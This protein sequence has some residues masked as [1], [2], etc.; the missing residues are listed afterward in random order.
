[1]GVEREANKTVQLLSEKVSL[2]L[3]TFVKLLREIIKKKKR[4]F[5]DQAD[6]K[7][8]QGGGGYEG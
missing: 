7:G 1:M 6:R 4:S 5:Y 3:R 8:G 2:F